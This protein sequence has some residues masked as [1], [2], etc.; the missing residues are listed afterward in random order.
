MQRRPA[1]APRSPRRSTALERELADLASALSN[2]GDR[3]SREPLLAALVS[4]RAAVVALA[5]QAVREAA[6]PGV[7][8][9]LVRAY[10][11]LHGEDPGC[12][13]RLALLEALDHLEATDDAPFVHAAR[14]VQLEKAWGAPVDTAAGVRAR[15]A[16]GLARMGSRDLSLLLGEMLA[17]PEPP[18]Q[19]A[20]ADA[21]AHHGDRAGAGLLLLR[22]ALGDTDPQVLLACH[23][24][25]L[26]V[27]PDV[28]L[29]RL[30]S[31]LSGHD[32]GEAE[33]AGLVLGQSRLEAALELLL[34]VLRDDV[35]PA[36]RARAMGALAHFRGERATS[37]LL[38]VVARGRRT[39]ATAAVKA[40]ANRAFE[41]DLARRAREAGEGN[42]ELDVAA[43][44]ARE[45]GDAQG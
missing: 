24:A 16:A 40:L 3:T 41:P 10:A 35:L 34:T 2:P 38:E 1:T 13:A 17:D 11:S 31:M 14:Y 4:P 20:A 12:R 21:L 19:A 37:A 36:R 7:E 42:R 25:L 15:A 29:P 39:D 28:S 45:F 26:Q 33:V 22:L 27:A 43:L 8:E 5:A 30:A 18:V 23:A 9:A 44:V 32:E 6:L